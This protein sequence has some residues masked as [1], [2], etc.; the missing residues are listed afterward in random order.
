[1]N[2]TWLLRRHIHIRACFVVWH[3]ISP[4]TTMYIDI[5]PLIRPI[6]FRPLLVSLPRFYCTRYQNNISN[7]D[8]TVIKQFRGTVLISLLL[9]YKQIN[10]K[11]PQYK[12]SYSLLIWET[13]NPYPSYRIRNSF[14]SNVIYVIPTKLSVSANFFI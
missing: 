7:I 1:M 3:Y 8:Q 5:A 11:W 14:L 4:P 9:F 10:V 13:A 2:T 6:F 12:S